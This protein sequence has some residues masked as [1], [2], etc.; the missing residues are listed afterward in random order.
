MAAAQRAKFLPRSLS[1]SKLLGGPMTEPAAPERAR[2]PSLLGAVVRPF[3]AFLALEAS[4]GILLLGAAVVALVWANVLPS[5]YAGTFDH[6]L[7]LASGEGFTLRAF[8]NDGLMSIFFFVVGM[9]IKRELVAGEL[10]SVGKASLPAVAA[11]GGIL[12]PAGIF[13]AFNAGGRGQHGWGIPMATDIAFC[14]GILTLLEARVPRSL[15]V[16]VTAL[17]IFD[18]VGG[19]LVIALFYGSGLHLGWLGAALAATLVLAAMNR[20]YVR[21]G[22]AYAFVGAALWYFIHH[23]G[24]HATIAGV[25]LGLAI[26]ARASGDAEAPIGRFIHALHPSVAFLVMPVFALANSGVELRGD[27]LHIT[28][29]VSLGAALGLFAGKPLGIFTFTALALKLGLSPMPAAATWGKLFGV[30]VVAGIGF[31]VALF[32]AALAFP[33]A[34]ELLDQ[35]KVGIL[36]GS[37]ASGL[38]GFALLRLSGEK[39]P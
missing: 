34:P 38:V 3:Q 9:E 17:A 20:A 30:A 25:V 5:T 1:G 4:S 13:L 32:I 16:F 23:G 11:L 21:S 10:D 24:V 7:A 29:P 31:T 18:D 35:A 2:R 26:P 6:R 37:F 19:I 12:V 33:E 14:V 36:L 15:V 8:I 28:S 39:R 27:G 22:L